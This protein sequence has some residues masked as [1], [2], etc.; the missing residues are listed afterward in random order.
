[1]KQIPYVRVGTSYYK[2]VKAPTIAGHFNEILVHWTLDT[3][4][5]DHGKNYLSKIPKYDGFTCI[6]S[7]LEYQQE[8][9][10]FYNT[11]SP[12]SRTPVEGEIETTFRF[13]K[14]IFGNH[15]ELGLDYLQILYMR[16]IQVLPILCLVSRERSTGKSTFLKWLKAIF[17]NNLTYLT[18]DSFSSQFNADWANKLL[19]CIDEVL[20]NKEELTERIKYLSTTNINKLEAKGKDKREVEFFGKFIL[21]S[22]NEE[23]FIKIDA[24]ETRFWVIKVPHIV[25]EETD[26]LENLIKE[27]PAFLHFLVTRELSSRHVTRM[28]FQPQQIMTKA[29]LRLI[30]NNRNRAEKE[31]ASILLSAMEHLEVDE[32]HLCPTD[33]LNLLNKTRVKTDLTQLRKMLKMDWELTNQTNSNKY[34]KL[35]IWG[36]GSMNLITGKGRYFTVKKDFLTKNFDDVMT[37]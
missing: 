17:E 27:I 6:P 34:Q 16:P 29:L 31:L 5:H 13:V 22:N 10:G 14:H 2:R 15:F 4:K 12:L 20:F 11:Y 1:M 3:I 19:I 23:N 32:I 26:F 9:F 37:E 7:H 25:Q 36:D 30:R 35:V 24:N 33:A 18:N 8:Y 21:C 28:W